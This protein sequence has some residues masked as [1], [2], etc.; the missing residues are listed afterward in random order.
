MKSV[1][2]VRVK[3]SL[4]SQQLIF[5]LDKNIPRAAEILVEYDNEIYAVPLCIKE[6]L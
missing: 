1:S 2:S 6:N 4:V 5:Q 3:S